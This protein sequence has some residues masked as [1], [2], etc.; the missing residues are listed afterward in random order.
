MQS[1]K[2]LSHEYILKLHKF[3]ICAVCV[4]MGIINIVSG[5]AAV[6]GVIV[7]AGI[8][9]T[10]IITIFRNIP[11]NTAAMLL[12]VTQTL[13]IIAAALIK[14]ELNAMF[15]LLA[16]SVAMSAT[17]YQMKIIYTITAICNISAIAAMFKFDAFYKDAEMS[18][19]ILG[20]VSLDIAIAL[21]SLLTTWSIR[22]ISDAK[23]STA[24][25]ERL[26]SVVNQKMS[27]SEELS[28]KLTDSFNAVSDAASKVNDSSSEMLDISRRLSESSTEQT[29]FIEELKSEVDVINSDLNHTLEASVNA[30]E[31][32]D[33]SCEA[34]A[35]TTKNVN[36]MISA[37][38]S[39]SDES[40]KINNI[41]GTIE[42]IAFQTN[43]LALN[44]A[45]E[46]ARAG[47]AGK[48]FAVVADE[49]RN[50]ATKSSEAAQNSTVLI[51]NILKMIEDGSQKAE[52]AAKAIAYVTE[53][54]EKSTAGTKNIETYVKNQTESINVISENVSQILD[55]VQQN[56]AT[57][58]KSAQIANAVANDVR[59]INA[60]VSQ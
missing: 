24:E 50:L 17:Y 1:K 35:E 32:A 19:V 22:F 3:I 48:G 33:Q 41:I 31:L 20:L 28:K 2:I 49:V 34:L 40:K 46:A 26:V 21:I 6:G 18:Q 12:S 38:Q 8:I 23:E 55:I 13:V 37:M 45:V 51:E 10:V 53:I 7:G 5:N 11:I 58:E 14:G 60:V 25:A 56:A 27:E 43:I 4:I 42:D 30:G 59:D 52:T 29:G 36:E 16:A 9:I 47:T 44:A 39:I 54:S 57:A 15:P